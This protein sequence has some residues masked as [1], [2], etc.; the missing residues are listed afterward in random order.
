MLGPESANNSGAVGGMV[1]L[2]T[3][4]LP[5]TITT[6]IMLTAMISHGIFPSPFLMTRNPDFFWTVVASMY[7]GNI[8]LLILNLPLVGV[9]ASLLRVPYRWMCVF[10]ILFCVIGVY[11][12]D[13]RIFDLVLMTIFGAIG[14]VMKKVGLPA[15]PL[16]LA[17]VL[18]PIMEK[19]LIQSLI[20]SDGSP[21]IFVTRPFAGVTL[22]LFFVLLLLPIFQRRIGRRVA[23]GD[24]EM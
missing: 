17:L 21:S 15:A 23:L 18:G 8:I 14:Y 3:L 11:S 13:Y 19:S 9:W 24:L 12:M 10:I 16:T 4:G 20:I 6:A 1:V 7:I 2:L 5:Y 22:F